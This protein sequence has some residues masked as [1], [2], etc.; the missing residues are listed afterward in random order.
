ML[1][2]LGDSLMLFRS[3]MLPGSEFGDC[4]H[5]ACAP[6]FELSHQF[7]LKFS[8]LWVASLAKVQNLEQEVSALTIMA[9]QLREA[10]KNL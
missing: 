10:Q 4:E 2:V 1:D 3:H 9:Q 5:K 6:M 8:P 7:F